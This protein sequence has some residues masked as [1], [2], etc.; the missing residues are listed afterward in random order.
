M[1]PDQEQLNLALLAAAVGLFVFAMLW[2]TR[3]S[4]SRSRPDNKNGVTAPVTAPAVTNSAPVS[5][6]VTLYD[7]ALSAPEP[8]DPAAETAPSETDQASGRSFSEAA[9]ETSAA[10]HNESASSTMLLNDFRK[11]LNDGMDLPAAA[12]KHG[13]TEDEARVAAL[14]YSPPDA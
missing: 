1:M 8:A 14:C 10:P 6:F 2:R 13:L 3:R 7:D 4:R 9:P 5:D 11:A 12:R